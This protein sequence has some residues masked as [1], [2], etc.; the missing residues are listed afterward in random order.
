M[1]PV[2][3]ALTSTFT[4]G[5]TWPLAV[6]LATRSRASTAS[7]FTVAALF[8]FFCFAT[9]PSA[10]SA[11][12]TATAIPIFM[13]LVMCLSWVGQRRRRPTACSSAANA[14]WKS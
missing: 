10:P 7:T 11:A 14:R 9:Y 4:R 5:R 3:S 6:T 8:L 2:M 1:R 12:T 13:P